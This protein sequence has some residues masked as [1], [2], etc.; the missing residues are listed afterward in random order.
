MNRRAAL[1]RIGSC[2]LATACIGA[3]NSR[4]EQLSDAPLPDWITFPE[5]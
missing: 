2:A 5:K 3:V 4:A 1:R